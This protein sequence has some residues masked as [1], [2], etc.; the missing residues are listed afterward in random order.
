MSKKITWLDKEGVSPRETRV[1]QIWDIDMNQ[2]KSVINSHALDIDSIINGDGKTYTSIALAMAVLPLP[3]DNTPFLVRDSGTGEDGYYIY[4]ASEAGGYLFLGDFDTSNGYHLVMSL[5]DFDTL[6]SGS[7]SGIWMI[8]NSFTLDANKT[9]P[10]EV[11]LEFRSA[12]INLG[13]FDLTGGNTAIT[14]GLVQIFTGNIGLLGVWKI[15]EVYPEW[16]GASTSLSDNSVQF[17][18]AIDFANE[19]EIR[20]V[21]FTGSQ[22][23]FTS[24]ITFYGKNKYSGSA[25]EGTTLHFTDCDGILNGDSM[26]Y[27]EISSMTIEGENDTARTGINFSQAWVCTF[28]N[29]FVKNFEVNMSL[30]NIKGFTVLSECYL[31]NSGNTV[32]F[33][34]GTNLMLDN[35]SDMLISNLACEISDIGI[36]IDMGNEVP[37]LKIGNVHYERCDKDIVINGNGLGIVQIFDSYIGFEKDEIN[38]VNLPKF[39]FTNQDVKINRCWFRLRTNNNKKWLSLTDSGLE[40]FTYDTL[41]QL[42]N[43][44]FIDELFITKDGN[45]NDINTYSNLELQG[46]EKENYSGTNIEINNILESGIPIIELNH[47]GGDVSAQMKFEPN[48]KSFSK[49]VKVI[50]FEY[51]NNTGDSSVD[52]WLASFFDSNILGYSFDTIEVGAEKFKTKINN[53]TWQKAYIIVGV[54]S[55]SKPLFFMNV[56][57]S[58]TTVASNYKFR[59]FEIFDFDKSLIGSS[60]IDVVSYTVDKLLITDGDQSPSVLGADRFILNTTNASLDVV[61]FDDGVEFQEFTVIEGS[62][63]LADIVDNVNIET[64][65][66]S[67]ILPGFGSVKFVVLPSGVKKEI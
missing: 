13:G 33:D 53:D 39:E 29:V 23:N 66:G 51:K 26:S 35:C 4:L 7:I 22:Y 40:F 43:E 47:V 64:K 37:Q 46:I 3:S 14:A 1:N 12:Q 19:R 67:N 60:Q 15:K 16:F 41:P 10:Q 55:N 48:L 17:Q 50:S 20:E 21:Y 44:A 32:T 5:S 31:S 28:R 59:H 34:N 11:T 8:T 58:G 63:N 24:S 42:Q 9:I 25:M 6:I 52:F 2:L 38:A 57:V 49:G 61:N 30:T 62:G 65:L 56:P 27:A 54:D 18:K 36:Q 45:I